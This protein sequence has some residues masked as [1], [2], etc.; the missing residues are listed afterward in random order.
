MK[1]TPKLIA[2]ILGTD[3]SRKRYDINDIIK[4]MKVE[5]EHGTQYPLTNVTND[6]LVTTLLITLA[7]LNEFPDYY[8]RLAKMEATAKKYW[9][10]RSKT[11]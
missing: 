9:S 8:K 4:G 2:S 11:K 1:L 5:L 10:H 7:H 3:L 6:N